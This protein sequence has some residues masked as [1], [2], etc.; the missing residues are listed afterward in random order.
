[1]RLS[2]KYERFMA[3]HPQGEFLE[4]T[5]AAGKTTVGALKFFCE[6]ARS[7]S[8]QHILSGL[9]LGT[10]EKNIIQK[11]YGVLEELGDLAEYRGNGT[12]ATALPHI[13]FRHGGRT[14]IVYVLGYADKARWKKALGGQ[15]GC[16]FI[17]EVNIAD[18]D[19][20]REATM[21]CDYFMA[22]LNPDDPDL[23]VYTEFV[24]KAVPMCPEDTPEQIMGA[25]T[26]E[27]PEW[28][29]WFFSFEDNISLTPDKVE[30]IKRN[31]P[32]GTKLWKNKVLGLRGKA[33]GLVFPTYDPAVHDMAAEEAKRLLRTHPEWRRGD[34][35]LATFTSGLDTSYSQRSADSISMTFGGITDR[36]RYILLDCREYNNRDLKVPLAPTDTVRNYIDFLRRN[37]EEW[38]LARHCFV[39]SADQATITELRKWKRAHP[40]CLHV[41]EGSHKRLANID[42]I[43]LQLAWMAGR[44]PAFKVVAERCSPYIRELGAYSWD[45]SRDSVPEDANDHSIQSC[46]YSWIP[47]RDRIGRNDGGMA[48]DEGQP[49]G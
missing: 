12:A 16:L 10:I 13:L 17:D 23:P 29:H 4:G 9:D 15:Y 46:Q 32:E 38:G 44:D 45:E 19:F 25:L 31:V 30:R 43:E 7:R 48:D 24:N 33:T 1:M 41:F 2:P 49:E 40:E 5:T 27:H 42:R 22:T 8:T 37:K 20:V 35:E 39:D 6:V 18:M 28:S 36:G 11:P 3:H 34:E 21:R 14:H 47:Y 26:G